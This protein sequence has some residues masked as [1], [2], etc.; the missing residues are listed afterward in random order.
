M[1]LSTVNVCL[2]ALLGV[3]LAQAQSIGGMVYDPS[4]GVVP[5]ALIR[6]ANLETGAAQTATTSEYGSFEAAGVPA[7]KYRL[8]CE[9][10]GF[11]TARRYI[12]V[13]PGE[14]VKTTI[15]LEL[16]AVHESV[17]VSAKGTPAAFP[18]E[19]VRAGGKVE[20]PKII[21]MQRPSYPEAAKVRGAAGTVMLRA[22]ILTNGS[23][24]A[25][26]TTWSPDPDLTAAAVEAVKN[27]RYEPAR[28]NGQPVEVETRI[29]I[30][31]ALAP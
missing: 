15:V 16:G 2:S 19:R 1:K 8:D 12:T 17:K 24:G 14:T 10:R 25:L 9:A 7:G 22:V 28:L 18:P 4:G 6:I 5:G 20:P 3:A 21:K 31:F 11:R 13:K 23:V 29:D 26:T 30:E 27:W